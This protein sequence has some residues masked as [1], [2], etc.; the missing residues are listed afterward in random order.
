MTAKQTK[1][2]ELTPQ[3]NP[4]MADIARLAGVSASTVSRALA[5]LP[6]ITEETRQR[7]E[8]AARDAG[9]TVNRHARSLRLRRSGMMLVLIPDLANPNFPDLLMHIDRAAFECGYDI[10]IAHTAIDPGRSDRF[11][12]EL[13]AGGIDGV[14][15][16]SDYC[17]PRLLER[18]DAGF[19]LP[20]VR[21]LSPGSV[22]HGIASVQIDEV[23]AAFDVV[24]HLIEAGYRKVMH[25]GGP[26][27]EVVAI[28]RRKGW[29]DAL[30]A[31]GL[32]HE[33]AQVLHG[34]FLIEDGRRAADFLVTQA[35]IP[36][37]IFCSN[38]ESAYGLIAGL[39]EHGLRVP[40][41]IAVAGFD[42]L[43]FSRVL[44][45]PLTTVRLP[46]REMAEASVRMLKTLI[47]SN[48][49]GT[50][51]VLRHELIIRQSTQPLEKSAR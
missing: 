8:K 35:S 20:I 6:P 45:P 23:A 14:L 33:D 18:L 27:E 1:Q 22:T 40:D 47:E 49:T 41:D 15:L 9:Y 2:T 4:T 17:P 37:A 29:H 26:E 12:D 7:V 31:H 25:L 16:T 30:H 19:R 10:M 28:A 36:E 48:T 50:D 43:A 32:P 24:S 11:V 13:L 21:T 34:G 5:G 42:D 51:E 39:K 44:D 46:R 38:D 3:R